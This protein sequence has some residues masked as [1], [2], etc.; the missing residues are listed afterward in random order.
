M[1]IRFQRVAR[2]RSAGSLLTVTA[3][4]AA[5]LG[6]RPAA[7]ARAA[8]QSLVI[9]SNIA[10]GKTMDPGHFY[11]FAAYAMA[12]NCYDSLVTYVGN[13]T[14]H[15]QPDLATSWTISGGGKVYTFKLRHGVKFV[16]GNPMTA[17]DVVFSYLRLKYLNDNP[18]FLISGAT[19]IKA[20]DPYTV[21]ITL[22]SPD[23][24]FLSELTGLNLGVLDSKLVIAHG[25]DD[26]PD[27]A[28]KDKAQSFLDSQSAGTNAY[29]M[30]NWTRNVQIVMV[31]NPNYWGP[32]PFF[33]KI[34]LQNQKNAATQR[35]LVQRG[36]VDGATDINIQQSQALIHDPSVQV[37]QG[38]TLNLVYMGMTTSATLSKPL[39]DPRVRQAVRYAIDYD[40]I[41]K[42]LLKG[43]GTRPNSMIPVGMLGNDTATNNSLLIHTDLAKA[44]SL[45][46]AAGYPNG[47]SVAMGYDVDTTY[48]GV[49]FDPIAA[50][51]QNDLAQIG[52]TV[53]LNPEQDTV[54][55]PQYRA[56][57][58]QMILYSWG[59]DYPDPND[60]AGPFSPG[61][62]P[63]KRMFFTWDKHLTD[64]VNSADATTD[65]G[66]RTALYRTIQE[67][68][69]QEGPWIGLVQPQNIIVLSSKLK[70]YTYS[71]VFQE[72][73]RKISL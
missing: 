48:D 43:V 23:A 57:K 5:G 24:S 51:V 11:E 12:P 50:K 9:S 30:T 58:L 55:L 29:Q 32:R 46:K 47:F 56:Q 39:S 40:G 3:V 31:R 63:A 70:G 10:D 64:L 37:I 25:G 34:V 6:V 28:K 72:D 71:P 54:L 73:F 67:T 19:S 13:D 14:I 60:Y 36:A 59:V 38:N 42:G 62:G 61:G 66:K 41:L 44:R 33:D 65:P 52:I 16:S 35:L 20:L 68:W 26:S 8:G 22:G 7:P 17:D 15:P 45:L 2:L 1:A 4:I 18:A 49:T 21:Q 27:A 69:L 53:K